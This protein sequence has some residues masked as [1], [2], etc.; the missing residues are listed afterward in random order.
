MRNTAAKSDL[1]KLG[2]V[3][4][5]VLLLLVVAAAVSHSVISLLFLL[6]ITIS[7][8]TGLRLV[9]VSQTISRSL[10][11]FTT[12]VVAFGSTVYAID[13]LNGWVDDALLSR[14]GQNTPG[15]LSS[16]WLE[17]IVFVL[18]IVLVFAAFAKLRRPKSRSPLLELGNRLR[19]TVIQYLK[20]AGPIGIV[21]P[22]VLLLIPIAC[23]LLTG[24]TLNAKK[25]ADPKVATTTADLNK[26]KTIDQLNELANDHA[27]R[28]F[29]T[30][31]GELLDQKKQVRTQN[32]ENQ[33]YPLGPVLYWAL[34]YGD[35]GIE[36]VTVGTGASS[37]LLKF[38]DLK[39]NYGF[40]RMRSRMP[41][42]S[43]GI[44]GYSFREV[45]DVVAIR[46]HNSKKNKYTH[47]K[48]NKWMDDQ[49]PEVN[50]ALDSYSANQYVNHYIAKY[51]A[52]LDSVIDNTDG[53][54]SEVSIHLVE[55][56]KAIYDPMA[57]LDGS[58]AKEKVEPRANTPSYSGETNNKKLARVLAHLRGVDQ[59][60]S[61]HA[62]PLPIPVSSAYAA[63]QWINGAIQ[64]WTLFLFF[65]GMFALGWQILDVALALPNGMLSESIQGQF[66]RYQHVFRTAK[67]SS[68]SDCFDGLNSGLE[69]AIWETSSRWQRRSL[70]F[71]YVNFAIP[72][73]G[74][75]GTVAGISGAFEKA[76]AFIRAGGNTLLQEGAMGLLATSVSVAFFTTLVACY[77]AVVFFFFNKGVLEWYEALKMRAAKKQVG[78][79]LQTIR[80]RC[81]AADSPDLPM[82]A[83]TFRKFTGTSLSDWGLGS[84]DDLTESESSE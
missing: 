22:V 4:L 68:L 63:R 27:F 83:R 28:V 13:R 12:V 81:L 56:P 84:D 5:A 77:L 47:V 46:I 55:D 19:I 67:D 16:I 36:S 64:T 75:L 25:T 32:S 18:A 38:E 8:A 44:G 71:N 66:K 52:Y 45:K 65:L 72:L 15:V 53:D 41:F 58:A 48:I 60:G 7:F 82:D 59:P 39:E 3:V 78:N 43:G 30:K 49:I 9:Y 20:T 73:F 61:M 79:C 17:V 70:F 42:V 26:A 6:A 31:Y 10:K 1:L 14:S 62:L 33:T 24:S 69:Q 54:R 40:A 29:G 76:P 35:C 34:M 57:F 74:L 21:M 11:L 50:F 80:Q 23:L 51:L 2:E 37:R